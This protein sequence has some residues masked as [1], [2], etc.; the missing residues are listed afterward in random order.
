MSLAKVISYNGVNAEYYEGTD[1]TGPDDT[2]F[3]KRV[4]C[5][6]DSWFSFGALPLGNLLFPL[7][8]E[9]PTL[10][11]NL[12]MPGDVIRAMASMKEN[13]ELVRLIGHPTLHTNWDA[14][15]LS[16]GGNDLIDALYDKHNKDNTDV[17]IYNPTQGA[18]DS[19]HD[20]INTKRLN[21][22]LQSIKDDYHAL[23]DYRN[24]TKDNQKVPII[25]HT[26]DYPT[27]RNAMAK[28]AGINTSGPWLYKAF[29]NAQ[30]PEQF[31]VPITN[32]VFAGLAD[33]ILSLKDEIPDFYV[34]D[35][36]NI[37]TRAQP[38]TKGRDGDWENE[39]H[40]SNA[41]YKKLAKPIS[42]KFAEV[43]HKL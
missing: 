18:G 35:T 12:A 9:Q 19:P 33:T 14:I 10:L 32:L 27:P 21:H 8:F 34:V 39:I 5:E 4:L 13:P 24:G 38:G 3:S 23:A 6:G 16:G 1:T 20:Y 22:V 30:V 42:A 17:V 29:Q 15:Y 43:W 31:W 2:S 36:R 28:V 41:G 25:T 26:Y 40:P 37:L 7:G 11:V